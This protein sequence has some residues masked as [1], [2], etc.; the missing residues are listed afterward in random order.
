MKKSRLIHILKTFNKKEARE[1]RKWLLSP[2]HN[3]REDVLHLFEYLFE[4]N[5]LERDKYLEKEKV[6]RKIYPNEAYS[7]AKM[8]QVIHFLFKAVES[9]LV[10][11]EIK[12]DKVK[13]EISLARVY[14][15]RSL[16]K[17]CESTLKNAKILQKKSDFRNVEYFRNDYQ[18]QLEMYHYVAGFQRRN[19][20]LQEVSDSL[21][22]TYF[23]DKLQQSCFMI[24]HE[25]VIKK[26]YDKGLLNE[27]LTY[28]EQKDYLRN[29]A[30]SVY[31]YGFKALTNRDEEH[32][33]Y[34]LKSEIQSFGNYFPSEEL[35]IVYLLAINYCISRVNRGKREFYREIFELYKN[36][37]EERVLFEN[38][39]ITQ[40]TFI[41]VVTNSILLKEYAWIER[42]IE[43]YQQFLEEKHREN[44]V[45]YCLARLNFEKRNYKTAMRLLV[46]YDSSDVLMSWN[47]KSMLLK[48]YFEL[49]E[50][51]AL[52]SSI[53]SVRTYLKRKQ[54]M[55]YHRAPMNNFI[56]LL[57]K[58][59]KV[60]PFDKSEKANLKVEVQKT[61][62][63][64]PPDK[65]W[66]I[67]QIE[68]L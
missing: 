62:P 39:Q 9:F 4:K 57:K 38:N 11:E 25:A 59:V 36:G 65:N 61:S 48:M 1:L 42:F 43:D 6:F 44:T 68:E 27:I 31:Y 32:F 52:D 30:I 63:L 33:F 35:R 46:Q 51:D 67:T 26:E 28:I 58:L 15:K 14:R 3:Q 19:V 53:E 66:L 13:A 34:S 2:A 20:N 8:R 49:D 50:L 37:M 17:L 10:Y 29:P 64:L 56:Q 12:N 54:I 45:H 5:H 22:T 47:A 60:N 18:L 24:A 7:D 40:W 21:D 55:G 16:N 41:N 23:A